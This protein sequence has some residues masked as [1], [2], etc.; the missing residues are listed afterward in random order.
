MPKGGGGGGGGRG[1]GRP[2][3]NPAYAVNLTHYWPLQDGGGLADTMPYANT[4]RNYGQPRF[5]G[6]PQNLVAA[7]TVVAAAKRKAC[8]A[9]KFSATGAAEES[10]VMN[11]AATTNENVGKNFT[12]S[13]W[14]R[15]GDYSA[16]RVIISKVESGT[17]YNFVLQS[18]VT[19][20][21]LLLWF[22]VAGVSKTATGT[23]A[24]PTTGSLAHVAGSYDGATMKVYFNGKLEGST[25]ETGTPETT[26]NPIRIG[27]WVTDNFAWN[28]LIAHVAMFNR[29]LP[30]GEVLRLATD[31]DALVTEP[32]T[33]PETPS[34]P[35]GAPGK[36]I[37][38]G[39][40]SI[41][42]SLS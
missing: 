4:I 39:G 9:I 40:I 26:T 35:P 15:A 27:R 1:G 2:R 6:D 19:T 13:A 36:L 8:L 29:A 41:P 7:D 38:P 25:A 5:K 30:A 14:V 17:P 3:I 33:E 20:G 24:I 37:T 28:G 18:D 16:G 34:A 31:V 12:L 10:I 21:F 23:T 42:A 11:D 32:P 22:S